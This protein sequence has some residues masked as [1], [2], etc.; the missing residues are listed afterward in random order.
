[1]QENSGSTPRPAPATSAGI[2]ASPLFTRSG[3]ERRT[4]ADL[5]PLT[6]RQTSLLTVWL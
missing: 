2:M 3:P 4:L 5:R 6:K 1:V